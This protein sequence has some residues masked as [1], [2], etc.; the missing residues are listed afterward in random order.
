[1]L[2]GEIDR[3]KIHA[4]QHFANLNFRRFTCVNN[5]SMKGGTVLTEMCKTAAKVKAAPD[6]EDNCDDDQGIRRDRDDRKE[7]PRR[8]NKSVDCQD[9][10]HCVCR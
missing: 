6:S 5:S 10:L 9:V 4:F 2:V 8:E 3:W 7:W 1:M